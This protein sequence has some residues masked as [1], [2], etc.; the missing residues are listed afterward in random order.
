MKLLSNFLLASPL[1]A[2]AVFTGANLDPGQINWQPC[3][4][5]NSTELIQCA[6]LTIPLDYTELESNKTLQLQLL[7]VPALRQPSKG[8]ILFNFGGP[9]VAGR[10][11]L[12]SSGEFFRKQSYQSPPRAT[13]EHHDLVTFDPRGTGNTLPFS[14]FEDEQ[15]KLSYFMKNP[16][17]SDK[18]LARLWATA[19]LF[20]DKCY[21]RNKEIGGLVGSAFVA[22]DLMKIVDALGK[23]GLLRYWGGSD[24]MLLGQTAAA[25]FPGRIDRMVLDGDLN[26]HEYYRGHDYEQ[27]TDSDKTFSAVFQSCVANPSVCPLAQRHPNQTAAQLEDTIYTLIDDL[28]DRPIP[29]NSLLSTTATSKLASWR[30]STARISGPS[31]ML[32]STPSYLGT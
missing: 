11:S 7:R 32:T 29:F 31:W 5:F 6:H 26:P 27:W 21:E 25:M 14:C 15:E 1:L 19:K 9:S 22:R 13:S 12:A 17:S 30:L 4:E 24:G 8:S 28:N 16:K 20:A 3:S 10:P 18:T 23:D 2:H